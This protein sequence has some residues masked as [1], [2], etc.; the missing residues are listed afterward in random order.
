MCVT[1]SRFLTKS[2][3]AICLFAVLVSF[4]FAG[5]SAMG[6]STE[7]YSVPFVEGA[8]YDPNIPEPGE[9]LGYP[10]ATRPAR[11][12]EVINYFTALVR[13]SDRVLLFEYGK[14]H[15]GRAL[16]YLV[17]SSASN[18]RNLESNRA[19][20]K[21]LADPRTLDGAEEAR[22]IINNAPAIAWMAYSI[23]GDELSSTDAAIWLAYQLLAGQDEITQTILKNTIVIIDPMQNPDGR[24][25][26]LAQ[27]R[28]YSGEIL[29]YDVQSAQHRGV[30]P[31]GRTNH[32]LF[33]LNR[34][35]FI[36]SQ[37]ESRARVKA[38]QEWMPQLFVD[39]HEMGPLDTYLF[40]P[41][42]EPLNVNL[43][44]MHEKWSRIY[45]QDQAKAFDRY[46]W[47]Y[48]TREWLDM[49][50][51]GYSEWL[52][53][54]GGAVMILYEQAGVDGS[55]VR[56][57]EGTTMTYRES[58]HHHITSSLAN[59]ST[60][61]RGRKEMLTDYYKEKQKTVQTVPD[62]GIYAY[63]IES[64]TNAARV[65][66]LIDNLL[67]QG[68]E[69]YQSSI[70][71]TAKKLTS[72]FGE[73]IEEKAF[74]KNTWIIPTNQPKKRLIDAIL[75]FDPRM[76]DSFL[77]EERYYLEKKNESRLYDV[78][79][80][81]M[82]LAYGVSAYEAAA[83]VDVSQVRIVERKDPASN[84]PAAA[85]YGYILP[86][87]D[88]ASTF[89]VTALLNRGYVVLVS[90]EEFQNNGNQ[91]S[92]GSFLLRKNENPPDLQDAIAQVVKE[93]HCKAYAADTAL[94]LESADLGG[95]HFTLLAAPRIG[96]FMGPTVSQYSYGA[97][98]HLLDHRY[99]T[100]I[101]SLDVYGAGSYDLRKYNVLVLP[102]GGGAMRRAIHDTGMDRLKRW[103]EEGGTLIALG[104][105][106]DFIADPKAGLSAVRERGQVL[107]Q[108]DLYDEVVER[109]EKALQAAASQADVWDY[110]PAEIEPATDV[111]KKPKSDVEKLK[112]EDTWKKRF[113]PYG[114]FFRAQT[115]PEHWLAY[116]VES[117]LAVM[118]RSSNAYLAAPPVQVPVRLV[119][120]VD[121][122]V[123]G[124]V[125]PEARQRLAKSCYVTRESK[126]RGQIIL[127]PFEPHERGYYPAAT[128]LLWNAVFLGPGA[129]ASQPI[130]W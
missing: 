97:F 95:G 4:P 22:E 41:P 105:A 63:I 78:S 100:R 27:L 75:Q 79:S 47:S 65:L 21:K 123:S 58:V 37:P 34:D 94:S 116:G 26:F 119:D 82:P 89:A 30:W 83:P 86:G 15:E 39:S 8:S 90:D 57:R 44:P 17:T 18:M 70:S 43:T 56:R 120:E 129:G 51:P 111:D 5:W 61:A 1:I 48:Y 40:S 64:G 130:P 6:H 19:A 68:I 113:S 107:D 54:A 101:S 106:V 87:D 91:F 122:R 77:Q 128:R 32:Y 38:F 72:V 12:E 9:F 126:G 7:A 73:Q 80:W 35:F 46:G 103:I 49:W 112:R 24:E 25:R 36:L 42:R 93:T 110:S 124:L 102:S 55:A 85:G 98:W 3:T 108:L 60:L 45:A 10:F 20:I 104:S 62:N 52:A 16:Y 118:V 2:F 117:P 11:Y 81:S 23:H 29:N 99:K 115:D 96:V 88:D 31:Y 14:T 69:L 125:W 92:K 114:A 109:E 66:S 71:F 74:Q 127:F 13:R 50:Y 84:I 121:L 33:D 76:K 53:Y 59:L 67:F 28:S